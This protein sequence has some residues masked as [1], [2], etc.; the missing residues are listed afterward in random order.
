MTSH[1]DPNAAPDL[2]GLCG[3][4]PIGIAVIDRSEIVRF[5][6]PAFQTFLD[7]EQDPLGRPLDDLLPADRYELLKRHVL[8]AFGGKTIV[9]RD[10]GQDT[11][12]VRSPPPHNLGTVTVVPFPGDASKVC[13]YV[14]PRGSIDSGE[15]VEAN[16][17]R[18]VNTCQDAVV[19]IDERSRI[20]FFNPAA[21]SMFG[22]ALDEV[23]DQEVALLMPEPYAGEHAGYIEHY[24]TTGE[25]K[26][27]GRIRRVHARRKGGDVFPIELSVTE[28][29][30]NRHARY[31]AFIRDVS[32]TVRLQSEL[33][34]KERL[35]TI[36]LSA[37]MLAHE[38]G[39]P[40]NNMALHA[41]ILERRLGAEG[42][43]L[44]DK[45]SSITSEIRRLA[46]LLEEFR[47][48]GRPQTPEYE[49]VDIGRLVHQVI[50]TQLRGI[51][52]DSIRIDLI[53]AESLPSIQVHRDKLQQVL[54]NLGK[55]AIE[56]MPDGGDLTFRLFAD[57]DVLT[58]EVQDTGVGIADDVDVFQP[59]KTTKDSGTGLGLPIVRRI[60]STHGGTVRHTST[61]GKGT[62]FIITLPLRR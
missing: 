20:T 11:R 26:A 42:H 40:L 5:A 41:Q 7:A 2:A 50:T 15:S 4:A 61:V 29:R 8:L 51:A 44:I 1:P 54:L 17:S 23:I 31:G 49:S 35:S 60:I 32:D 57:A 30:I 22:Y 47:Q 19:F 25:M 14:S 16:F 18:L 46:R 43:A 6:N 34:E 62:T 27:I 33:V 3:G 59:F 13:V 9:Y 21:Q 10:D 45:A 28:L 12:P 53:A 24:Q 39:N 36:G 37:S 38:V 58:I 56:A 55:N 52:N 48:Y